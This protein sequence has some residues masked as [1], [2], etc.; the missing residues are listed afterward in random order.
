MFSITIVFCILATLVNCNP[1][2]PQSESF[3]TVYKLADGEVVT[4]VKWNN[5]NAIE[6]RY[7]HIDLIQVWNFSAS[8]RVGGECERTS[9][10]RFRFFLYPLHCSRWTKPCLHHQAVDF[11]SLLQIYLIIFEHV[12]HH[13]LQHCL[14]QI[15][16][17]EHRIIQL[18]L[19]EGKLV[20]CEYTNDTHKIAHF[21]EEFGK[22][23]PNMHKDS[24]SFKLI[25]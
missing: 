14:S 9:P 22:V 2:Q 6:T 21:H 25:R 20:D 12:W 23:N 4:K 18:W 24:H 10:A 16:K 11:F 17:D 13:F 3:S 5:I 15:I 1:L 8:A 19:S 7:S